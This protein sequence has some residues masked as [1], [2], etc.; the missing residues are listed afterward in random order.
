MLAD[1]IGYSQ[2]VIPFAESKLGKREEVVSFIQDVKDGIFPGDPNM[3]LALIYDGLGHVE[4]AVDYLEKA[5][6]SGEYLVV[7]MKSPHLMSKEL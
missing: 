1:S 5:H 3:T 4:L 2:F 7:Y 6:E